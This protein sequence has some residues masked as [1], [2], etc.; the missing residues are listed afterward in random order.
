MRTFVKYIVF[1]NIYIFINGKAKLSEFL[2][3]RSRENR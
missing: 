3:K 1:K 2:R